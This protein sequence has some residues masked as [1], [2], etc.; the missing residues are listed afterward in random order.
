MQREKDLPNQITSQT[1]PLEQAASLSSWIAFPLPIPVQ[2]PNANMPLGVLS[3]LPAPPTATFSSFLC[4]KTPSCIP[5]TPQLLMLLP[6]ASPSSPCTRWSQA[7]ALKEPAA[8]LLGP[9]GVLGQDKPA[10]PA[11]PLRFL[12]GSFAKKVGSQHCLRQD[13]RY[14]ASC[15][16]HCILHSC[17]SLLCLLCEGLACHMQHCTSFYL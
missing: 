3:P 1:S 5:Q 12:L 14:G 13:R 10:I 9:G 4:H 6:A 16:G 2:A 11:A 15:P 17:F 7:G 8:P